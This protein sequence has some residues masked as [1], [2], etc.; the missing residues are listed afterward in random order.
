MCKHL[1]SFVLWRLLSP[2]ILSLL[3]GPVEVITETYQ[4]FKQ[5]NELNARDGDHTLLGT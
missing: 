4:Y 2:T 1:V 3:S 5:P